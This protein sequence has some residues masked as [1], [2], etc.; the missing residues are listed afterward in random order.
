MAKVKVGVKG[1]SRDE[2]ADKGDAIKTAMTGNANFR[3]PFQLR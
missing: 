3:W 1:L 2:L